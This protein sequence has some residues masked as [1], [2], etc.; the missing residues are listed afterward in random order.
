M[1]H[2][3]SFAS[4]T[5]LLTELVCVPIFNSNFCE[6][7]LDIELSLGVSSYFFE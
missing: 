1:Q 2:F 5:T 4:V 3:F 7:S 6:F